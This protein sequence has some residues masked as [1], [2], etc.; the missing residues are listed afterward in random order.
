MCVLGR[1]TTQSTRI[2]RFN[3]VYNFLIPTMLFPKSFSLAREH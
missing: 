3:I 1:S 2:T